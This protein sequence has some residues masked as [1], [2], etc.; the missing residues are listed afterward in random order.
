MDPADE[1][2]LV[3]PGTRDVDVMHLF[4]SAALSPGVLNTDVSG[5]HSGQLCLRA[6][7]MSP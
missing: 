1:P 5:K 4:I 3:R 2:L 7:T 6:R